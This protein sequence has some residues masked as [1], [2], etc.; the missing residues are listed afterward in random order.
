MYNCLE[1]YNQICYNTKK[2]DDLVMEEKILIEAKVNPKAGKILFIIECILCSPF[3]FVALFFGVWIGLVFLV[4]PIWTYYCYKV[5][6]DV[7]LVITNKR[8]IAKGGRFGSES[9]IP[10][11][12]ISAVSKGIFK[13]VK[14]T[15][16][17]GVINFNFL[18]NPV[19]IYET[20]NNLINKRNSLID[21]IYTKQKSNVEI[22]NI[23]KGT[24]SA[25][26]DNVETLR[27]YKELLDEGIL[28]QEEFDTK[29]K[30]LLGL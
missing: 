22:T 17:S 12:S 29:K 19:E 21:D 3:I 7:K 27:H 13:S 5:S 25:P 24:S 30:E 1:V 11:D 20:I 18:E 26:I 23:N 6:K 4:G 10:I 8:V 28:T 16:S 14:I 2:G 9:N 15:S